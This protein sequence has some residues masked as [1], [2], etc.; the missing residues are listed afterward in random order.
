[1]FAFQSDGVSPRA[2]V[3]CL[4]EWAGLLYPVAA[5]TERGVDFMGMAAACDELFLCD[6]LRPAGNVA[7]FRAP[8]GSILLSRVPST[9]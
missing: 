7:M 9:R 8:M 5:L 6:H 2:S 1:M 3:A 4:K